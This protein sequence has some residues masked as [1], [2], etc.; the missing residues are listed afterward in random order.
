MMKHPNSHYAGDAGAAY[1]DQRQG[2]AS[3]HNQALRASLF[4]D[5]GNARSAILD[6]GCGTGGVVSRVTAVRRIGVE[7]GEAAGEV[8]RSRGIEVHRS[9]DEVADRTVD[10]AISFHA[11]EHVDSPAEILR[12]LVRVVR[13]GGRLRLI[14]PS[15]LATEPSEATWR[16]NDD[17]HLYTWTPLLFGNLAQH[18]GLTGI[19]AKVSP[20]PTTSRAVRYLKFAPPVSRRVHWYLARRRNFLNTILDARVPD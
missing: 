19:S 10:V 8:A 7:I 4:A 16:P 18:C 6:F 12:E 11:L 13:P 20:M 1:L 2:A 14:V 15:E 9:L 17:M 5:L 3:D